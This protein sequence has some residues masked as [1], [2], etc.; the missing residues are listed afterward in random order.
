MNRGLFGQNTNPSAPAPQATA[1]SASSRRV[2]PQ[3]LTSIVSRVSEQARP[4]SGRQLAREAARAPVPGA[5][6]RLRH[7]PL[8]DQERAI[9]ERVEPHEIG[10]GVQP[11]LADGDHVRRHLRDQRLRRVDVDLERPQVPI[12]HADDARAGIEGDRQL[13]GVVHLDER[14]EPERR[15][16]RE[17]RRQLARPSAATISST[18]SAPAAFASSS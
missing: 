7:E 3:I 10:G 9:A 2:M 5:R 8:A 16:A 14:V 13:V 12:V 11:A 17:K 18:A 1:A 6:I 4:F 15:R